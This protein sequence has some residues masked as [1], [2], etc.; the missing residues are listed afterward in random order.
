MIRLVP[1]ERLPFEEA[2][3]LYSLVGGSEYNM[4]VSCRRMGHSAVFVSV[5]P[6]NPYGARIISQCDRHGV[7]GGIKTVKFDGLGKVRV[8]QY[9]VEQGYGS[10]GDVV[11]YDRYNSAMSQVKKGDLDWKT[12]FEGAKW[13]HFSGITPALGPNVADVCI[14]ACGTA[15]SMGLTIS[16]DLNYRGKLW[17]KRMPRKPCRKLSDM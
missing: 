17:S 5:V 10:R 6:G 8:G 14:D 16:I 3:M 11:T 7:G 1:L 9:L 4:A 15:R 13:F 12:L 2:D